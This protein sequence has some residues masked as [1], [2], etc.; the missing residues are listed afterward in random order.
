MQSFFKSFW[1][2][3]VT[4]RWAGAI[5][6]FFWARLN[7]HGHHAVSHIASCEFIPGPDRGLHPVTMRRVSRYM[8]NL[9]PQRFQLDTLT[10]ELLHK[11]CAVIISLPADIGMHPNSVPARLH[12]GEHI[13]PPLDDA[14]R[15]FLALKSQFCSIGLEQRCVH[16]HK[17]GMSLESFAL[18]SVIPTLQVNHNSK[19]DNWSSLPAFI[20]LQRLSRTIFW[21]AFDIFRWMT[22]SITTGLSI[23]LEQLLEPG[24]PL[25]LM[26]SCSWPSASRQ[27]PR[28]YECAHGSSM[29]PPCQDKSVSK[30]KLN[31]QTL[32]Y[33]KK[34]PK[35]SNRVKV[36]SIEFNPRYVDRSSICR[37][38][39]L[40]G[41]LLLTL[42]QRQGIPH[43]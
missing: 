40:N 34:D 12:L 31:I 18:N 39:E 43:F 7:R 15:Q 8:T 25:R 11:S 10:P 16:P 5:Q 41:S 22:F 42:K 29:F 1:K 26:G 17:F 21:T 19:V 33:L 3:L 24:S 30:D 27:R 13:I 37:K 32:Q 14:I 4:I 23:W 2:C 38:G 28:W 35:N 36:G 6:I 9:D 20:I